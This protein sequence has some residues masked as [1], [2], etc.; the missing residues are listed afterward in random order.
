MRTGIAYQCASQLPDL[1]FLPDFAPL[2]AD[3][4]LIPAARSL[5]P[6]ASSSGGMIALTAPAA[7]P[8][9]TLTAVLFNVLVAALFLLAARLPP[10]F[11][12][13]VL[14]PPDALRYTRSIF[15]PGKFRDGVGSDVK[16]GANLPTRARVEYASLRYCRV[17]HDRGRPPAFAQSPSSPTRGSSLRR[18][19]P[20]S[21]AV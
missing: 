9:M 3:P 11:L 15:K 17:G 10:D 8:A 18:E 12:A 1:R 5:V 14:D 13:P 21:A 7:A 19:E 16:L 6:A 4:C 2:L 20:R